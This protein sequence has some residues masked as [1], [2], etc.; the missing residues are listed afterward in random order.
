MLD[1][2][3]R[4]K[5]VC[6]SQG[7]VVLLGWREIS[8]QQ[9]NSVGVRSE[10]ELG[11]KSPRLAGFGFLAMNLMTVYNSWLYCPPETTMALITRSSGQFVCSSLPPIWVE[12]CASSSLFSLTPP[13]SASNPL[14]LWVGGRGSSLPDPGVCFLSSWLSKEARQSDILR[15]RTDGLKC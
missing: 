7:L 2:G 11:E 3:R 9:Q 1:E 14:Y 4:G 12:L 5:C 6:G 13:G 15:S 8:H 10:E